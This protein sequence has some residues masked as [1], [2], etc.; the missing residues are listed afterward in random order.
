MQVPRAQWILRACKQAIGR[1]GQA[2]QIAQQLLP[3]VIS[4]TRNGISKVSQQ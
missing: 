1:N 2:S 3:G 4:V